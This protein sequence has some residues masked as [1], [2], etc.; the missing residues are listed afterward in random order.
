[1]VEKD[2]VAAPRVGQRG[3]PGYVVRE[4]AGQRVLSTMRW[5]FPNPRGG[6]GLVN[7]RNYSSSMW[8][9]ALVNPE[10]RCLVPATSF[11]EWTVEPDPVT[12]KKRPHWFSL[13]GSPIFA[14]AG[15]W[16][17]TEEQ[18]VYAF[19][20]C[21]YS[22]TDDR[23]AEKRAASVHAVGAVHPKACPVILHPEDYNRWLHADIDEALGLACAFPSQL[24]AVA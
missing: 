10:R 13:R 22:G 2:Y 14:F 15:I 1:M 18:P 6:P 11:Q 17:P 9:P 7:V 23:E 12:G 4:E 19:L 21:G 20:T 24:I 8:R 16:R 5:G 3:N